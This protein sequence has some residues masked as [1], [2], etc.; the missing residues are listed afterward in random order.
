MRDST[1]GRGH[2][3]CGGREPSGSVRFHRLVRSKHRNGLWGRGQ[4]EDGGRGEATA[5]GSSRDL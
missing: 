3:V 1:P 5:A 2:S 4:W